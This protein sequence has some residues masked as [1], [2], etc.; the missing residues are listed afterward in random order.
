[1]ADAEAAAPPAGGD[2]QQMAA[3]IPAAQETVA[4]EQPAAAKPAAQEPV[5][6]EKESGDKSAGKQPDQTTD[7]QPAE[8]NAGGVS[9]SV[10]KPAP[11]FAKALAGAQSAEDSEAGPSSASKG[12]GLCEHNRQ[13]SVCKDCGGKNICP[14]NR[15]K[16]VCKDCGGASIC[17]HKRQR[18]KCKDCKGKSVCIHGRHKH[19]CKE[20]KGSSICEHNRERRRCKSC[21]FNYAPNYAGNQTMCWWS[22]PPEAYQSIPTFSQVCDISYIHREK[23]SA[24]ITTVRTFRQVCA[25]GWRVETVGV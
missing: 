23:E 6:A 1:M 7:K 18:S 14:H 5:S 20:C 24:H 17:E 8:A 15:R 4:A 19:I 13:R 3:V 2:K 9:S 25:L 16:S 21:K 22:F 11:D 12:N 10:P